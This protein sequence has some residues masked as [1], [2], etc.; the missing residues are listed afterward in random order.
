MKNNTTNVKYVADLRSLKNLLKNKKFSLVHGVFDVIHIGHKRHFETANKLT[1]TLLV[2]ITSDKFVKKGPGRPFF[3][4]FLRSEMVSSLD[5]VSYV[6]IN[7]KETPIDLIKELK[8]NFYCKGQDYEDFSKD[9]TGNIKKEAEAIKKAGGKIFFTSDIQFSSSKI[10]NNNLNSSKIMSEV[11]SKINDLNNFKFNIFKNLKKIENLKVAIFGEIIEDEYIYSK[12]LGQPSKEFIHAVERLNNEVY[13]GGSYAI[14]KN[15]REFCKKVDV[16]SAGKFQ[17]NL[18]KQIQLNQKNKINFINLDD[19]FAVI[20]K[21]R[22]LNTDKKK[23]F[24]CYSYRGKERLFKPSKNILKKLKSKIKSYDCVIISDFGHGFFSDSLYEV[25]K[26]EAK[27]LSINVQT[28]AGNRGYNLATKYKKTDNLLLDLPELQ[29]ATRDNS[30]NVEDLTIKLSKKINSKYFAI[31]KGKDGI[32]IFNA[33]KKRKISLSAFE[34]KPLDTMGAG[35]SVLGISSLLFSINAPLGVV[36]YISNLFGAVS[37][38]ILG[39]SDYIR[40]KEI[41]KSIEY[42]LK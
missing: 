18:K 42:G 23:L 8:P 24:E 30:N 22:Y 29:L 11:K 9:I 33:K 34:A 4:E 2:S 1:G 20:K 27:F 7:D 35:D 17:S 41:L 16:F 38:S 25:I 37:T 15:L 40:K 10:I 3:N 21:T 31:T 19:N 14:A 32:F 36:A 6:Y 39:H 28:N 5:A 26:K 12:N 13:L